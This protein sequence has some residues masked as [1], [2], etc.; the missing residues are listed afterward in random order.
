M[1]EEPFDLDLLLAHVAGSVGR[2]TPRL[3]ARL[4]AL[5]IPGHPLGGSSLSILAHDR[6]TGMWREWNARPAERD[7]RELLAT[8]TVAGCPSRS[9]R[10]EGIVDTSSVYESVLCRV[11]TA[12]HRWEVD[13]TMQASGFDGPD[14]PALRRAF[15]ALF[16]LAGCDAFDPTV[17]GEREG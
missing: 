11:R 15:R 8:L 10:A 13:V 17:F 16:A 12:D 2:G 4:Q 14:A 1:A 5:F 6:E 3:C 7:V 9:A